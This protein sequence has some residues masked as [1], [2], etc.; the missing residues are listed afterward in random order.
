MAETSD[1]FSGDLNI[2]NGSA[3]VSENTTANDYLDVAIS[4][5]AVTAVIHKSEEGGYWC[6][7]PA[8]AG[9]Y[10]Q[11]ETWEE[12][13]FMI[14]DAIEG[15]LSKSSGENILDPNLK[16]AFMAEQALHVFFALQDD[17]KWRDVKSEPVSHADR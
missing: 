10:S 11:G 4:D 16:E 5:A 3:K 7:V 2:K 1:A 8:I 15:I 14:T 17:S 9:C 13:C 12:A 6:S